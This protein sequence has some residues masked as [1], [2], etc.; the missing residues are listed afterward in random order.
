[1]CFGH[2]EYFVNCRC[3]GNFLVRDRCR[4]SDCRV[5]VEERA[6][7]LPG[8]CPRCRIHAAGGQPRGSHPAN[9]PRR[10][11]SS[12][13][14]ASSLA[15]CRWSSFRELEAHYHARLHAAQR[16]VAAA[17]ERYRCCGP[18]QGRAKGHGQ[19]LEQRLDHCQG[20]GADAGVGACEGA[21]GG[22]GQGHGQG[23][24]Q[25]RGPGRSQGRGGRS[26]GAAPGRCW[27]AL[28]H[29]L[30]DEQH[31]RREF[32]REALEYRANEARLDD[33]EAYDGW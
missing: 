8:F 29:A 4:R 10:P 25:S 22:Q 23:C 19:R 15:H 7:Y 17:A 24:G 3:P 32:E 11:S 14:L 6:V 2:Q 12:S 9:R 1:M 20:Q 31:L 33:L 5:R 30:S 13:S 18:E 28:Q 21:D 16:A 27:L 26:Y